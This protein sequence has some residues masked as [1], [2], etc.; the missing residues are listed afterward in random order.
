MSK[1]TSTRKRAVEVTGIYLRKNGLEIMDRGRRRATACFDYVARE[2][3]EIVFVEVVGRRGSLPADPP[4][5]AAKR[6]QAENAA[7]RWLSTHDAPSARVRFDVIAVKVIDAEKCFVRH[8]RD[9]LCRA[10]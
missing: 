3:A 7:A 10:T 4:V 9:A 1:Q 6:S 8:H 5:S 2:G